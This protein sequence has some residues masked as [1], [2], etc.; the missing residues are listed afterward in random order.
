MIDTPKLVSELIVF[1]HYVKILRV[2]PCSCDILL[3]H[4]RKML[5]YVWGYTVTH[6]HLLCTLGLT[7]LHIQR[8][9]QLKPLI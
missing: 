4:C 2:L 6:S 8:K 5:L 1:M 3:L 9:L 7:Y